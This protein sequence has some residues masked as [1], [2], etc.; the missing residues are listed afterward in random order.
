MDDNKKTKEQLI[1]ELKELRNR[2]SAGA[3][4]ESRLT[5]IDQLERVLADS[6]AVIY[7]CEPDA[8]FAVTYIS[9]N[10]K[11]RMGC[12]AS[13]FLDDPGFWRKRIHPDDAARVFKELGRM[14]KGTP[15]RLEY[16]FLGSDSSCRWIRDECRL[17]PDKTGEPL[18]IIGYRIDITDRKAAEEELSYLSRAVEQ[19]PVTVVI[20]DRDGK[21]EYANPH[22]TRLTGYT[23]EEAEGNDPSVLK[24]GHHTK[25]F[26]KDLWDTIT[27]GKEWHGEFY[28][29]NKAGEL[30]W[31]S[32]SISPITNDKGEIT[33]YVAV[34]EDI[35]ERKR[36]EEELALFR[37]RL[38]QLVE[39][40]TAELK[41]TH[42][43]LLISERLAAI[44][45][46]SGAI[47]HELRNPLA[48]A[49]SSC[50]ILGQRGHNKETFFRHVAKIK[51]EIHKCTQIIESI[52]RLSKMEAPKI[53]EILLSDL[54]KS[55]VKSLDIPETV[56]VKLKIDADPKL[57]V[58]IGQT[59]IAIK[60]LISNAFQAMADGGPLKI[61]TCAV[62]ESVEIAIIDSGKG[63]SEEDMARIFDPLFSTKAF[64]MGFGL[65]IVKMIIERHNGTLRATS[66]P[67]EGSTFTVSLPLETP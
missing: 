22:F 55:A 62:D 35:T 44:G 10:V 57:C 51:E 29:K 41:E 49:D 65:S 23:P 14:T 67:G 27:S 36:V 59:L 26:Y 18:E 42:N 32:A 2:V 40:R 66:K 16:R 5:S 3:R 56:S 6:P 46:F 48:T 34:K 60:N 50:F 13:E 37:D 17:L 61:N 45:K 30:F 20:T 11:T 1:E 64:G 47:A 53:E 8:D 21:I 25:E 52:Q 7:T 9:D 15:L 38:M 19:S 24:S 43:K 28:N 39:E 58:D 63:I 12:D 4:K 31:E 54:I 33:H